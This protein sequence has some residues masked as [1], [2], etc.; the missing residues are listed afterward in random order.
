MDTSGCFGNV[1]WGLGWM[2]KEMESDAPKTLEWLFNEPGLW[3]SQSPWEQLE[4]MEPFKGSLLLLKGPVHC[5]REAVCKSWCTHREIEDNS[6][7]GKRSQTSQTGHK[8]KEEKL[9]S[10]EVSWVPEC[11]QMWASSSV[12]LYENELGGWRDAYR[13]SQILQRTQ[14]CF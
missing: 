7:R 1:A 6:T 2:L 8:R 5:K 11:G 10:R 9:R 3:A 14:V 4:G 12:F 13:C